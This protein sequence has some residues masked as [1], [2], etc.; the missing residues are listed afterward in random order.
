MYG[1]SIY[2]WRK[3]KIEFEAEEEQEAQNDELKGQKSF[4]D[5]EMPNQ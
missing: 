4:I 5:M 1:R 2:W 3:N